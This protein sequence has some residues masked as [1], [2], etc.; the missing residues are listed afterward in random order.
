MPSGNVRLAER[1]R[2]V[3]VFRVTKRMQRPGRRNCRRGGRAAACAAARRPR[4]GGDLAK[5]GWR[6]I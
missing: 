1:T 4:Y 5:L 3:R 2:W 6:R